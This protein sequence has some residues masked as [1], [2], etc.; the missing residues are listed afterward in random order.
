MDERLGQVRCFLLDMDG[1]VNLGDRLLP[2]VETFFEV[3]R[4]Q[5]KDHLFLTNNSSRHGRHYAEKMSRLGLPT[6]ES[7]VFTSGEAT[8]RTLAAT[9]PDARVFLL[10]TREL[11]QDFVAQGI[12]L[13]DQ[14]PDTVVLGFDTTLTYDRL[15][16]M[17]DLVRAGLP[18]IATHADLNCPTEDGFMPDVGSM[19]AL[20]ETSTGRR[21]DLIVG[22]PN[23]LIVEAAAGKLGLPLEA[24]AMIG[25]RLYT[26]IALGKTA[27]ILTVLVLS[28]EARRDDLADSPDLPDYIFENLGAVAEWLDRLPSD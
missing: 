22:K 18:F 16:R 6:P 19:L 11:R 3:L 7:K 23:R 24:L 9:R 13:D 15:W 8:A 4:R 17:C 20:V 5:H 25:D 21:P 14:T 26:D 1:T 27:G 12:C 10:G 28:G 2:G